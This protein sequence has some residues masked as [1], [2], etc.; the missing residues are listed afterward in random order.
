M[1]AFFVNIECFIKHRDE[2][3]SDGQFRLVAFDDAGRLDDER[4]HQ[5]MPHR[6]DHGNDLHQRELNY[7][8]YHPFG[9]LSFIVNV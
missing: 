4:Y 8:L 2:R 6:D 5:K 9:F 1:R 3:E 7:L